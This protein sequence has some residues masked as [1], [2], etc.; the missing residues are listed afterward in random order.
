[1]PACELC[2]TVQGIFTY[3]VPDDSGN[4]IVYGSTVVDVANGEYRALG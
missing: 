1:M 2:G 3:C 4:C